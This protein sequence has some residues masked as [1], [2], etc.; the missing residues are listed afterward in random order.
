[1]TKLYLLTRNYNKGDNDNPLNPWRGIW[2]C[3][4][5]FVVRAN[6]ES[7]ARQLAANEGGNEGDEAWRDSHWSRCVELMPVGDVGV[8]LRDF[9][10]G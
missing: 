1:M 8:V 7:E 6:N 3:A 2:D 10:A 9:H 5:G 4:Y